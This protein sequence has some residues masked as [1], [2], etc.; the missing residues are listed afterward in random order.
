[1]WLVSFGYGFIYTEPDFFGSCLD[2]VKDGEG[3]I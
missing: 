2:G 3:K 1:L